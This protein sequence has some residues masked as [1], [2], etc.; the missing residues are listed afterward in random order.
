MIING[1]DPSC[2]NSNVNPP[3]WIVNLNEVFERHVCIGLQNMNEYYSEVDEFPLRYQP[4]FSIGISANISSNRHVISPE[5][6]YIN[7]SDG[8]YPEEDNDYLIII[9]AKNKF[10]PNNEGVL[11]ISNAD[12]YQMNYYLQRLHSVHGILVFPTS[13]ARRTAQRFLI[14]HSNHLITQYSLPVIGTPGEILN[15]LRELAEYIHFSSVE[16]DL[17]LRYGSYN[18]MAQIWERT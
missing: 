11:N 7:S 15:R 9:D 6:R 12:L 8:T 4:H 13:Q 17:Q 3:S 16:A 18:P 5:E 1:I 14:D 2:M 10:N